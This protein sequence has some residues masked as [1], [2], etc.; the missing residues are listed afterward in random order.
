MAKN[1]IISEKDTKILDTT[2]ELNNNAISDGEML[3]ITIE[4]HVFD[5]SDNKI[6]SVHKIPNDTWEL[7]NGQVE[8]LQ[9]EQSVSNTQVQL[10]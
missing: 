1:K 10:A 3:D 9:K 5:L 7:Y 4:M 8:I 2:L 6:L